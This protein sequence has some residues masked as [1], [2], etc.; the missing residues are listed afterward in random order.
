MP[1]HDLRVEIERY[2]YGE[3]NYSYGCPELDLMG[4]GNIKELLDDMYCELRVKEKRDRKEH[5]RKEFLAPLEF[6]KLMGEIH[7]IIVDLNGKR[8]VDQ[9]ILFLLLGRYGKSHRVY[10]AKQGALYCFDSLMEDI[11]DLAILI[12]GR[13][14]IDC[15]NLFSLLYA[16]NR[17]ISMR[18]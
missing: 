13:K 3:G 12:I 4:Y 5:R 11:S 8:M 1:S 16:F 18:K 6:N 14:W 2:P 10:L 9:E 15:K 7:Q 17:S